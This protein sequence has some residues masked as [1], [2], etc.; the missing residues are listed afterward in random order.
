MARM[1]ALA[2]LI[3]EAWQRRG[4]WIGRL[5]GVFVRA[6][7]FALVVVAVWLVVQLGFPLALLGFRP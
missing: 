7:W 6:A 4:F 5:V 1:V 3:V 2:L